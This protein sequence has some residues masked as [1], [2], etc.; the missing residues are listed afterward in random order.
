MRRLLVVALASFAAAGCGT[1][2]GF[3]RGAMHSQ[4]AD[5][6]VVTEDDIKRALDAKPQLP[7]PFRLAI[8]LVPPVQEANGRGK[9]R[10]LR[11]DKQTLLDAVASMKAK[12]ALSNAF[13]ID[14]GSVE[15]DDNRA[16]RL[17][18]AR[19]GADAVLVVRGTGATDRSNN[20]LCVTYI[21]LVPALFVPGSEIDALFLT[22]ASLW[23]V[24]NQY[25]YLS[26]EAEGTAH[27]T[28]PGAFMNENAALTESK[29]DALIALAGEVSTR[30]AAMR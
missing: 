21:L 9:W 8:H 4:V 10:W 14:P 5:P 23:D 16:V 17:A 1:A 7:S 13:V 6:H 28:R 20:V 25:L 29:H 24:R 19:A 22:S 30:L 27:Q 12:G 11:E 26:A 18:A 3:D 15:G 2:T